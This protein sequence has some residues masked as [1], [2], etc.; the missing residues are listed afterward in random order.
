GVDAAA[1][2]I[3]AVAAVVDDE[4]VVAGAADEAVGPGTAVEAVVGVATVERVGPGTAHECIAAAPADHAVVA[5]GAVQSS[6]AGRAG[7][8]GEHRRDIDEAVVVGGERAGD[9]KGVDFGAVGDAPLVAAQMLQRG[10]GG[11][12]V[13]GDAVAGRGAVAGE[14]GDDLAAA[15]A[16]L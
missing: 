3:D 7:D 8:R 2:G 14:V 5:V 6:G 10:G 11:E 15:L 12:A 16:G 4:G 9:R 1:G 13:E